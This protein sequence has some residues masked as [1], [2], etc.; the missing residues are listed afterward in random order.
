L[1]GILVPPTVLDGVYRLFYSS[2]ARCDWISYRM[3]P[4]ATDINRYKGRN[5]N[6]IY[7]RGEAFL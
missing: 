5:L 2:T 1:F 3:M 6:D 4:A 7:R